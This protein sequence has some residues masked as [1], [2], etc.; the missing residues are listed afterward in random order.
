MQKNKYQD[1]L[2]QYKNFRP[3]RR[4]VLKLGVTWGGATLLQGACA[5]V[6]TSPQQSAEVDEGQPAS[7]SVAYA[8][9]LDPSGVYPDGFPLQQGEP[10]PPPEALQEVEWKEVID[11]L[12]QLLRELLRSQLAETSDLGADIAERLEVSQIDVFDPEQYAGQQLEPLE[13]PLGEVANQ[14]NQELRRLLVDQFSVPDEV[15][16]LTGVKELCLV[17]DYK[18]LTTR[19]LFGPSIAEASP[20]H[21]PSWCWFYKWEAR[22]WCVACCNVCS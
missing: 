21:C 5:P 2:V 7:P 10:P 13:G 22:R 17:I 15:A 14:L 6:V 18:E 20:S 4:T 11:Q 3:S 8:S 12:D 16:N 19:T 1:K 9:E